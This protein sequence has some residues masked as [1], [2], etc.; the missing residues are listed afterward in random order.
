MAADALGQAETRHLL[1]HLAA[2]R[3]RAVVLHTAGCAQQIR[4]ELRAHAQLH[5]STRSHRAIAVAI[6]VRLLGEATLKQCAAAIARVESTDLLC[7]ALQAEPG[8]LVST[9]HGHGCL[10]RV[11]AATADA[12]IRRKILALTPRE[13]L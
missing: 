8:I 9:A 6:L 10:A 1:Q 3:E 11:V 13:D 4:L 7:T 5:S 2:I 12:E